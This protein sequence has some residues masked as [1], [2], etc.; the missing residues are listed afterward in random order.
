[1]PYTLLHSVVFGNIDLVSP[2]SPDR[3]H[4]EQA[5]NCLGGNRASLS[6]A[7]RLFKR[8]YHTLRGL[9]DE[10]LQPAWRALRGLLRATPLFAAMRRGQLQWVHRR[11]VRVSPPA[12]GK[13]WDAAQ[14]HPARS[15]DG[16]VGARRRHDDQPHLS[17]CAPA[18]PAWRDGP[19][20]SAGDARV[21]RGGRGGGRRGHTCASA[22][23]LA[24]HRELG[25][26]HETA[27]RPEK[28]DEACDAVRRFGHPRPEVRRFAGP[29]AVARP[30]LEPG[31]PR[32]SVAPGGL[33]SFRAI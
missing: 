23:S 24:R 3:K 26:A 17:L 7:R 4:L 9:G 27:E 6:V 21:C 12:A 28:A 5:A 25:A 13:R 20:P 10:A 15:R 22:L 2:G 16:Q 8:S 32:F 1:M 30:G 29:S 33:G 14:E 11:P 31:T 18:A 19:A